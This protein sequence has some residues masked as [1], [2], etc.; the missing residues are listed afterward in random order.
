MIDP[1][2]RLLVG[3]V[4]DDDLEEVLRL[5]DDTTVRVVADA[6]LDQWRHQVLLFV[7]ID[8][9][10]RVVPRLA[11]DVEQGTSAP[12]GL[13]PGP[14][15]VGDRVAAARARSPLKALPPTDGATITIHIGPGGTD[16][17]LRVDA[18]E[19]QSYLGFEPSRLLT[20]RRDSAVGPAA[21][22]CRAAAAVYA[23]VLEPVRDRL[24][25][26]EASYRSALTHREGGD[27]IDDPYPEPIGPLDLLLAG[28]GSVGGAAALAMHYEQ[29][30]TGHIDVCDPQVLDDT[31][32][33]RALL[34]TALAARAQESKAGQVKASLAHHTGLTVD[35]HVATVEEWDA[36]RPQPAPLPLT[37]VA[38]DS[39]D[40]RDSIQ[41][42]LPLDVVN[43]AVGGDLLTVSGHRTG[44]GPCMCCLHM[45]QVLDTTQT[46]NR[47]ISDATG[48][49]QTEV[50]EMR[51]SALALN[52]LRVR[53][54]E[55]KRGLESG[56]MSDFVGRTL[57]DL[58]N[59]GILY[60]ETEVVPSAGK[61]I[62]VA[63]PFTTALAGVLLAAEAFKRSTP[64]L[65]AY[66]LGAS[67]GAV[68]YWEEPYASQNAILDVHVPRSDICIC[69]S[70]RRLRL[71]AQLYGVSLEGMTA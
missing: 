47:L 54:I 6:P 68:R 3:T 70:V 42:A 5:L 19:W 4:D 34:A 60:G 33:F 65:S 35:A 1:R 44:E 26:A 14:G 30:L 39:R 63:A 41:D 67:G 69:R 17:V 66:V 16:G 29:G 48:I 10:G 27:P 62:A 12:A 51:V 56:S 37:L 31:N 18:S 46:K 53:Q 36:G 2:L 11:I 21:A 55:S 71:T 22:A 7:L 15:T 24:D 43:A 49:P 45:P 52:E 50:N 23:M 32:P 13:P 38:V 61:R 58:W 8:L 64:K 40:A 25:L 9:L 20:A 28:A 59:D 57:D